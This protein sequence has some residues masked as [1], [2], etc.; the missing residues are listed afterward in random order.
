LT[1][2]KANCGSSE[3]ARARIVGFVESFWKRIPV[4]YALVM[5]RKIPVKARLREALTEEEW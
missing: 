1:C 2:P 3:E 5:S 4:S